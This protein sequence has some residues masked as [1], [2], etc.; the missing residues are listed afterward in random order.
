MTIKWKQIYSLRFLVYVQVKGP[1]E[2]HQKKC[3]EDS[4]SSSTATILLSYIPL[5]I[6]FLKRDSPLDFL[7]SSSFCPH[8]RLLFFNCFLFQEHKGGKKK[9]GE[10]T[11]TRQVVSVKAN[12]GSISNRRLPNK[13]KKKKKTSQTHLTV[14]TKTKMW[15]RFQIEKKRNN[16]WRISMREQI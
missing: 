7:E 14:K 3:A 1:L 8:A 5:G 9:G 10:T 12:K 4:I 2:R 16:N 15:A 6:D 13:K 11:A